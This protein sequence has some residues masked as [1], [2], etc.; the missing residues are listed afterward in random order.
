[1]EEAVE[2]SEATCQRTHNGLDKE[3]AGI[4]KEINWLREKVERLP[5]WAVWAMWAQG[6]VIGAVIGY[7]VKGA[8]S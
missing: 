8:L 7:A 3:I 4:W 1:M 6:L 2:V 5:A